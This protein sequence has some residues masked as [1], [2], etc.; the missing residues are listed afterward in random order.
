MRTEK[1]N[2]PVSNQS[3]DDVKAKP[4]LGALRVAAMRLADTRKKPRLKTRDLVGM[5]LSHGARAW[6][7]SLPPVTVKLTVKTPDGI[8]AVR[9][10]YK[11]KPKSFSFS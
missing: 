4:N 10:G 7:N 8:S 1:T 3:K 2:S 11:N 5:L 9:V 6:R